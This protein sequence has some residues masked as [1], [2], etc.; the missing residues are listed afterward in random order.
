MEKL[1][2]TVIYFTNLANVLNLCFALADDNGNWISQNRV[3]D[4]MLK[5]KT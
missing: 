3:G 1:S 4:P 2:K 5:G